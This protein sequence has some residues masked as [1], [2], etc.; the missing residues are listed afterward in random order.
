M[1]TQIKQLH[2]IRHCICY[3]L[4][5]NMSADIIFDMSFEYHIARFCN[6][7][8]FWNTL[9]L[10]RQESLHRKQLKYNKT[11]QTVVI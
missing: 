2:A 11:K 7:F 9:K 3:S 6:I 8:L 1:L 5:K 4:S 10:I